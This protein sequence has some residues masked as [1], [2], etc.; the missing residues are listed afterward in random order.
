MIFPDMLTSDDSGHDPHVFQVKVGAALAGWA[1]TTVATKVLTSMTNNTFR[2]LSSRV[3]FDPNKKPAIQP[4]SLL[5][6]QRFFLL[7]QEG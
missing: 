3:L 5:A 2:M 7:I 6:P 1:E 4:V